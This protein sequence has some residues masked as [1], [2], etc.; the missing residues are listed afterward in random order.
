MPD[1]LFQNLCTQLEKQITTLKNEITEKTTRVK[2]LEQQF[3][4]L[5][6]YHTQ[7]QEVQQNYQKEQDRLTKLYHEYERAEAEN[8][9]L[10]DEL[11]GWQ[12][13]VEQNKDLYDRLFSVSPPKAA[14]TSTD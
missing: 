1:D 8:Q 7:Y 13:W 5:Q 3:E 14:K 6:K 12:D 9:K 11:K 2:T 10:R 4:S